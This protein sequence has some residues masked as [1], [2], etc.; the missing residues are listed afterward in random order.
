[1]SKIGRPRNTGGSLY[2]RKD[3]GYW[4]M[5]YRDEE[6]RPQQ[7]STG[8]KDKEEAEKVLRKVL[9]ARDEGL[10]PSVSQREP[11]TFNEWAD[12]FLAN[13]SKPPFCSEKTHQQ[14]L[15]ALKFLRPR[16]GKQRLSDITSEDIEAYLMK[17][18]NTGKR[19]HT[20]LGLQVRGRLKPAT[21]HQEFRIL[22]RILNVAVKKRRLALNPCNGVEFPVALAGT[23][24]KPHYLTSSEQER[25][26]ACAPVY[27]RNIIVIM[28]EMGL[29]PYRELI[30]TRKEHVD[31]ENGI[32]HLPD[33]KTA[34]GIADMPM[35]DRARE[36]FMSQMKE[37]GDSEYLFPSPR[38]GGKKP[39]ITTVRK[40]WDRTLKRAGLPHFSLYELR[41]TFATRLSAGGVADHFVT[42]MLRQGDASVFKR[43]SQAK[44]N[45]MREALSKLDRHANERGSTSLTVLAS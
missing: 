5:S 8:T 26:E 13:R 44:L 9:V 34:N 42:Q 29:R 16:F 27:L 1:M 23:T 41:H 21:V 33:S 17:R 35:T 19:V 30:P 37:S 24:R 7:K 14:N 4:W 11:I 43:Y 31:I 25:L 28:V 39:H 6:G 40:L 36:A 20:K 32:V 45:M 38:A 12:W 3:S 2:P 10:L 22:G 18:L 15:G